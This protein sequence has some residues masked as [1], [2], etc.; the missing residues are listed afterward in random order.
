LPSA[1]LERIYLLYPDPWPKERQKRR[2]FVSAENLARFCRLLR[3]GGRFYFASDIPDYVAWT[4]AHVAGHGTFMLERHS[5]T[6]FADWVCT[7]YEAK[8]LREG[9]RPDYLTFQVE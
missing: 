6:P 5:A 9:R 2:R 8:A 7:R 1:C 4:L 3:P